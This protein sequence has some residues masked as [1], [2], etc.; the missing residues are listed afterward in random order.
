MI[1]STIPDDFKARD[2]L[3]APPLFGNSMRTSMLLLIAVLEETFPA[4]LARYL[5]TSISSVQRTLD[6]L[7][8]QGLVATRASVY[9]RVTLNPLYPAAKELKA[10]LLRI[11]AGYP[12]YA[13]TNESIRRRPR[14]RRK[15]L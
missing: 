3:P 8:E 9:R 7:E 6:K 15:P 11:A 10:F 1:N 13:Q 12:E 4:Q 14:R 5:K 2:P